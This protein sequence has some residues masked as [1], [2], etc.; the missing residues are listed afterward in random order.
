MVWVRLDDHFDENPKIASVGPLGI[1][2]WVTGLAYCNRN[3][4]DGFIPWTTA[5]ALLAWEY[6]EPPGE[7]G[8]SRIQSLGVTC[9]M[10]GDDVESTRVI[11]L[12]VYAGLW[13]VVDEPGGYLIHDYADFQPSKVQV[14]EDRRDSAARTAKSRLKSRERNA[15]TFTVD[16]VVSKTAPDPDPDPDPDPIPVP[17]PEP[18]ENGG[19]TSNGFKDR[20]GTMVTALGKELDQRMADEFKQIAEEFDQEAINTAIR[21]CRSDNVRPYPSKVRERLPEKDV[22]RRFGMTPEQ[23]ARLAALMD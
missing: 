13:E 6:L 9:G 11:D 20:Y 3:L 14:L 12:L 23:E 1:A 16:N 8:R 18:W 2:L 17:V 7:N 22:P 10:Q 4:T 19:A 21:E 5:R 15:V